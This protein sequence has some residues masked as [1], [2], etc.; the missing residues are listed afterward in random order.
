MKNYEKCRKLENKLHTVETSLDALQQCV[1]RI[2]IVITGIPDSVQDTELESRV[3]STLSNTDVN[4]KSSEVEDCH[5]IGK[6]N[7]GSKKTNIRFT[8][9]KYCK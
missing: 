1:R 5:R 6:S 8:I 4:V 9:R 2:N 7:N 3:T